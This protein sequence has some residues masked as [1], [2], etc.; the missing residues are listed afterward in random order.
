[1]SILHYNITGPVSGIFGASLSYAALRSPLP[2]PHIMSACINYLSLRGLHEEGLLR[3]PGNQETIA[4]LKRLFHH[5]L[6]DTSV[7][8]EPHSVAGLLKS[9]LR[10]LSD[11]LIP[12]HMWSAFT[13]NNCKS[14]GVGATLEQRQPKV[15]ILTQLVAKLPFIHG[16]CLAYLIHFLRKVSS[17]SHINKMFAKNC[18]MVLAPNVFKKPL[19]LKANDNNP[20]AIADEMLEQESVLLIMI[21]H[22]ETIFPMGSPMP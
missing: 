15:D 8:K 22:F 18:A 17:N 1:M 11:G 13:S 3:I 14:A 6:Q 21:E 12:T 5:S 16:A 20:Q 4:Y 9:Y 7:M 2:V 19:A 10:E